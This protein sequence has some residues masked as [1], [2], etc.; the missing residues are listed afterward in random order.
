MKFLCHQIPD[1][2]F[3]LNGKPL[4]I[5]SRCTG[6]YAGIILGFLTNFFE[7]LVW[8]NSFYPALIFTILLI[9]IGI[10]GTGQLLGFW[11]SNN[12]RRFLTGFLA[13]VPAGATIRLVV[14]LLLKI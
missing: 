9:P 14:F 13:G 5:C 1:R 10:D 11:K 3:K 12:P 2:C 4:P 8:I 6:I 7:P